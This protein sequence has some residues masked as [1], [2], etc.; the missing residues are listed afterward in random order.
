MEARM[1]QTRRLTAADRQLFR[2]VERAVFANP[3]GDERAEADRALAG[4]P[5]DAAPAEAVER[6]IARVH[7]RLDRLGAAAPLHLPDF[8][9]ADR[10]LVEAALLYDFF[11]RHQEPFDALIRRQLAAGD[12]PVAVPFARAALGELQRRGFPSTDA[13]RYLALCFQL[14]RAF[15]FIHE[16]LLGGSP[17]MGQLRR[18][19][20]NNVFT[21]DLGLYG[22]WLWRRMEDFS[23]LLLGETGTGK[24]T[25]AAAI[26]RSGFIPFDPRRGAFAESFT[27]SFTALNLSQFAEGLIESELFGHRKGAFTGAVEDH[28][29]ALALCSPHGAVFLDEIGEVPAPIQIKLLQVLQERTF[30]PVGSHTHERFAGR[31]VAAT[32]RSL[33]ELLA[34]V[35]FRADFYYRLCSDT[36]VV[37][38]LRQRLAEAPEELVTLVAATVARLIGQ[39]A[40]EPVEVA[41]AAIRTS[42]GPDYAWPG[43]VRE[44]EQCVRRI[45][46]KRRYDGVPAIPAGDAA[47]ELAAG[48]R[49]GRLTARALLAGYAR[50]LHERLGSYGEAAR[51]LDLDWRTVKKYLE[52]GTGSPVRSGDK[53]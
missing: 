52:D 50:L 9:T 29:G 8:V 15:F 46:L 12:E 11:Y 38:P 34:G 4:A 33:P 6:G 26:G 13:E 17:C 37:P 41:L 3:F 10:P 1:G 7:A 45:L 53:R 48:M 21:C 30:T 18:E 51:R 25:A 49:D 24:G 28:R 43:N 23:T 36:I 35:R 16:G 2:Q 5:A 14:R 40:P 19:L 31:I 20:W 47:A 22:R 32:N 44:L 39:P 27:R 42:P